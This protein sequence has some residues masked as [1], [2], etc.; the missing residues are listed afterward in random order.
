MSRPL[1]EIDWSMVDKLLQAHTPGTE[2]AA[3]FDM[4]PDTFY[5]RVEKEQGV[6][7]SEYC[8]QKRKKGCNN[9]RIAQFKNAREGNTSMQ[10]WLGKNWL[11]QKDEPKEE[12]EFDGSLAKLLELLKT[13]VNPA[14]TFPQGVLGALNLKPE[15]DKNGCD[16]FLSFN[17]LHTDGY[18]R[19]SGSR[20][21]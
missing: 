2:I 1:K 21:N 3:S 20:F 9:L 18:C 19:G 4:H 13:I 12:K 16:N 10:I 6:G 15:E 17:R 14:D 11:G 7:F 8:A 5:R